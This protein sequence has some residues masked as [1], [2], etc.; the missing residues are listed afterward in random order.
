MG[1]NGSCVARG[2]TTNR[3]LR[4]PPERTRVPQPSDEEGLS[5]VRRG[6]LG[7]VTSFR[8]GNGRHGPR[9][10]RARRV[11]RGHRA[12]GTRRVRAQPEGSKVEARGREHQDGP[13]RSCWTRGARQPSAAG[14]CTRRVQDGGQCRAQ[15]TGSSGRSARTGRRFRGAEGAGRE[16][17]GGPGAV[18]PSLPRRQPLCVSGTWGGAP[19]PGAQAGTA[20]RP[21]RRRGW[22][23]PQ[24]AARLPPGTPVA[25][26]GVASGVRGTSKASAA[27]GCWET[28]PA[29]AGRE[30]RKQMSL[31]WR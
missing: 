17:W 14:V 4:G 10:P 3:G 6:R 20:R 30:G 26:A 15:A 31:I 23:G 9:E 5:S 16:E 7:L 28:W 29:A 8:G 25:S 19:T 24:E 22:P 11:A 12:P 18:W 1:S 27:E 2:A 13:A 21:G